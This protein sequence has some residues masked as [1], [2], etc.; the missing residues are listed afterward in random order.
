MS[1]TAIR[2]SA[3]TSASRFWKYAS[4]GDREQRRDAMAADPAWGDYLKAS[5]ELGAILSQENR[6]LKP[7]SFS[8]L[9]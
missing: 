7:A 1:S 3:N 9:K 2:C 5:A 4:Q 6:I 8:P